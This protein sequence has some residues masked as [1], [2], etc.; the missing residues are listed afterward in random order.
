[1]IRGRL[2]WGGVFLAVLLALSAAAISSA[3]DPA[4]NGF[5]GSGGGG[6]LKGP[7]GNFQW[8][9]FYFGDVGKLPT[10][11]APDSGPNWVCAD[12]PPWTFTTGTRVSLTV[13]DCYTR[14]DIFEVWDNG[15]L[16]GTTSFVP[17]DGLGGEDPDQCA[18]DAEMS[19]GVFELPPG[20]HLIVII[21]SASPFGS[22]GAF[23]RLD[24]L[25]ASIPAFSGWGMVVFGVL[26][27]ASTVIMLF[28]R[29]KSAC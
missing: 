28:R 21:P 29:R 25:A 3:Q 14:G 2:Q 10:S 11:C 20:S 27:V 13:T 1:M 23:F 22:G 7:V 9:K 6:P 18:Q 16:L 19:H 17:A 5:L 26:L 24:P 8:Y 15:V 4:S 12:D